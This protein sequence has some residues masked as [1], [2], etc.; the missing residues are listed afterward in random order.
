M[1]L[2][3]RTHLEKFIRID[4]REF[5]EILKY[6]NTRIIAKKENLLEEGHT[7]RY[8]YFVLEGLLRQFFINEKEVEQTTG[9]AIET[10]WMTDDLAYEHK[11]PASFHIQAVEKSTILY[12]SRE[13]ERSQEILY[14]SGT[15]RT[16]NDG[17]NHPDPSARIS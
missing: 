7:C 13:L 12:I 6:F 9:F 2:V 15:D 16:G 10:C 4:D 14:R 17:R 5:D 8:H 11:Q 1:S 3:F